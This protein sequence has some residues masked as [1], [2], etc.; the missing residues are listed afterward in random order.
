MLFFSLSKLLSNMGYTLLELSNNQSVKLIKMKIQLRNQMKL[1][2][3]TRISFLKILPIIVF[4]FMFFLSVG[5]GLADP[6]T[7]PV[8]PE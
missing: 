3:P 2:K 7:G 1:L 5:I 4:T 8:P 6:G